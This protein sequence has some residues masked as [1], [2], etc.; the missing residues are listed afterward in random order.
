MP[1]YISEPI[2]NLNQSNYNL[3]NQPVIG[4]IRART[5]KYKASVFRK[6]YSSGANRIVRIENLLPSMLSRADCFHSLGLLEILFLVST[7]RMGL[8]Y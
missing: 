5:D 3:Q 6:A 4:Q 8:H 7:I 1:D 2:T